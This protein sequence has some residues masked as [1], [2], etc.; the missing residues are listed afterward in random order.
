MVGVRHGRLNNMPKVKKL[1]VFNFRSWFINA[2]RRMY[3]RFPP[4]YTKRNEN[5][6][7]YYIP[8]KTGKPKKRIRFLCSVCNKKYDNKDIRVDHID[9]VVDPK[10]GFPLK[11]DGTDDWSM[12]I[13]R[14]FC[15]IDNLDIL[16]VNCHDIKTKSE[17]IERKKARDLA[18]NKK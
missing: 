4:Y 14:L 8:S 10:V 1:K 17:T 15:S 9:P 3:R 11:E 7:I 2:L 6:E 5:K 13:S 12:Y 16:C 18:K